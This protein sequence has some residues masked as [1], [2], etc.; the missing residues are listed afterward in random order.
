MHGRLTLGP[1]EI[2]IGPFLHKHSPLLWTLKCLAGHF[3]LVFNTEEKKP[4]TSVQSYFQEC[5]SLLSWSL[6]N[7]LVGKEGQA[8]QTLRAKEESPNQVTS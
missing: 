8:A 4:H 6:L 5:S 3:T 1:W 7:S 2:L